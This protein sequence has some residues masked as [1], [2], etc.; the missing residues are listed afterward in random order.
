M[1][2]DGTSRA[3]ICSSA[4]PNVVKDI[5]GPTP[6]RCSRPRPSPARACSTTA[7]TSCRSL[8]SH[9][10]FG[11]QKIIIMKISFGRCVQLRR[12][13]P[14]VFSGPGR[15]VVFQC[16]ALRPHKAGEGGHERSTGWQTQNAAST[17]R[18]LTISKAL[19]IY[20]SQKCWKNQSF[21]SIPPN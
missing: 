11:V 20:S 14:L 16:K 4:S 3:K 1:T 2:A 5:T 9:L 19:E 17:D 6:G 18:A 13:A 8:W 7:V 12:K 10:I 21:A 15:V